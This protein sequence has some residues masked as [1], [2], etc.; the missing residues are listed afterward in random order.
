MSNVEVV[1]NGFNFMR[2]KDYR[3]PDRINKKKG[4]YLRTIKIVG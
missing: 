1:Y 4:E 3:M 2:P